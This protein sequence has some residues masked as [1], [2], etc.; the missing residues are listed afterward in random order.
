MEGYLAVGLSTSTIGWSS[1]RSLRSCGVMLGRLDIIIGN[2]EEQDN[3]NAE[4]GKS[5]SG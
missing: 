4:A 2:Y 3:L 1:P 5:A